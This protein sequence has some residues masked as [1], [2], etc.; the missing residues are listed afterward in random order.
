MKFIKRKG[1]TQ[2]HMHHRL[3]A[4]F[5]ALAISFFPYTPHYAGWNHLH[6]AALWTLPNW[7][8]PRAKRSTTRLGMTQS[9]PNRPK[10]ESH[11]TLA[12]SQWFWVFFPFHVSMRLLHV[13][14]AQE[15]IACLQNS[16]SIFFSLYLINLMY[17]HLTFLSLA[18]NKNWLF[19]V[20]N[21]CQ[22]F[23]WHFE[24]GRVG[25]PKLF[26]S[27]ILPLFLRRLL[28]WLNQSRSQN[29]QQR[30]WCRKH[31]REVVQIIL[32]LLL[33]VSWPI[34]GVPLT[35]APGKHPS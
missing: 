22:V 30:G 5:K 28:Q 8:L 26:N 10:P 17:T 19:I 13:A 7:P 29:R 20:L 21:G 4:V 24:I 12:S 34:K 11:K 9:D 1:A 32:P 18:E 23:S 15:W 14:K 6:N 25:T 16:I 27:P 31:I 33:S 35:A 2:V 3:L